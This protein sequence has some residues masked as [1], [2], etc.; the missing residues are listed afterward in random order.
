VLSASLSFGQAAPAGQAGASPSAATGPA[1]KQAA[2]TAGQAAPAAGQAAGTG[3]AG[4]SAG[5]AVNPA[6]PAAKPAEGGEKTDAIDGG[7]MPTAFRSIALGMNMTRVRQLLQA[8]PAYFAFQGD[9]DVSLLP[10]KNQSLIETVGFSF[11][12]RAF[13][14]F[15]KDRLYTII[16]AL[17]PDKVDYYTMYRQFVAKYGEPP[18]LNPQA[19]S[20]TSDTVSL[21]LER[22]LTVKYIDL[23]AFN[24]IRD[25]GTVIKAAADINRQDFLNEF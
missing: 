23:A 25:A 17:N 2:G 15:Y 24:E 19:M 13:F 22:P 12:K 4:Q 3:A 9:E 1:A 6:G 21:S 11:V 8:D 5:A 20:W 16:L 18:I 10:S 14:Q 7:G